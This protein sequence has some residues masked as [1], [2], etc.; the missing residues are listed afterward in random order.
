MFTLRGIIMHLH[1]SHHAVLR[2][3]SMSQSHVH[4]LT[5]PFRHQSVI[6]LWASCTIQ[7]SSSRTSVKVICCTHQWPST[8]MAPRIDVCYIAPESSDARTH[9]NRAL[10]LSVLVNACAMAGKVWRL[11][12]RMMDEQTLGLAVTSDDRWYLIGCHLYAPLVDDV[13]EQPPPRPWSKVWRSLH[14]K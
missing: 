6:C 13:H 5:T 2:H 10:W 11:A 3:S 1:C 8:V 7:T 14:R 9:T 12:S 4:Q